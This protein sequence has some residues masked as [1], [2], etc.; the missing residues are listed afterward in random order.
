MVDESKRSW[1]QLTP[2]VIEAFLADCLNKGFSPTSLEAYRRNL[3]KL[4]N[5]LPEDKRITA[6]TGPAWAAGALRSPPAI[7]RKEEL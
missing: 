6:G 7:R 5:Y 2:D 3:T 4:Y 1:E